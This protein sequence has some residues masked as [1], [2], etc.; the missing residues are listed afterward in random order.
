MYDPQQINLMSPFDLSLSLLVSLIFFFPW[1]ISFLTVSLWVISWIIWLPRGISALRGCEP[2]RESC[3]WL[4]CRLCKSW[5]WL[6]FSWDSAARTAATPLS[7][8]WCPASAALPMRMRVLIHSFIHLLTPA[9]VLSFIFH[10]AA[11]RVQHEAT[12]GC[13]PSSIDQMLLDFPCCLILGAQ[14]TRCISA[15]YL[16]CRHQARN[17]SYWNMNYICL[18]VGYWDR[19]HDPLSLH[20]VL[21]SAFRTGSPSS[22]QQPYEKSLLV[23]IS[24]IQTLARG[25]PCLV[26]HPVWDGYTQR[27][28]NARCPFIHTCAYQKIRISII[29]R[30]QM[31]ASWPVI[32]Y[33]WPSICMP[34]SA[35]LLVVV[36]IGTGWGAPS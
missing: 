21:C 33:G 9:F 35:G 7:L 23:F 25:R 26:P 17:V 15:A 27:L 22:P 31:D 4:R 12:P 20:Q 8:L 32:I 28:A 18:V 29:K 36:S 3:F 24:F 2:S 11:V 6:S 34:L 14:I 16:L 1:E 30:Y 5:K 10:T 19:D 13:F